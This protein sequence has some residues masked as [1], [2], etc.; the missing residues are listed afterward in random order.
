MSISPN[1]RKLSDKVNRRAQVVAVELEA[2]CVREQKEEEKKNKR[3][4]IV[5]TKS[6]W[7]KRWIH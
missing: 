6:N 7:L 1:Y 5:G 2:I 3:K 4:R